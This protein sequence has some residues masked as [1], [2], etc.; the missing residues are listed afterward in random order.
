MFVGE[1]G[2]AVLNV[3][4]SFLFDIYLGLS[5]IKSIRI[6]CDSRTAI[7]LIGHVFSLLR[8]PPR[9]FRMVYHAHKR[10]NERNQSKQLDN[11]NG[12]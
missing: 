1:E 6:R 2:R 9:S 12:F 10:I 7:Q 4:F 3:S 11:F 5:G 8:D